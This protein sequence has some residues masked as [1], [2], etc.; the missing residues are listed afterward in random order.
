VFL[1]VWL[2]IQKRFSFG[3]VFKFVLTSL[4]DPMTFRRTQLV[5]VDGDPQERS[6]LSKAVSDH[7]PNAVNGGCGWHIME[8]GMKRHAPTVTAVTVIS[9]RRDTFILFKKCV[10]DWCCSWMTAGGVESKDEHSLSKDA[11]LAIPEVLD[12]CD[13][14]QRLSKRHPQAPRE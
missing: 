14:Q 5:M 6:E 2:R 9:G 12:A 8:Q 11:C 10:K 1:K 7:M 13:G 3:W 4:L